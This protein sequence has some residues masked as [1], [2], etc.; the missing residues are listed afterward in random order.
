MK[1]KIEAI[2]KDIK[3]EYVLSIYDL[4]WIEEIIEKHLKIKNNL[5][6]C[7]CGRMYINTKLKKCEK[8]GE[9]IWKPNAKLFMN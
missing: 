1:E 7:D 4:D 5:F 2:M 6:R 3:K 9:K 8:C